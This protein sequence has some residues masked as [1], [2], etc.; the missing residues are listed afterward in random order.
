MPHGSCTIKPPVGYNYRKEVTIGRRSC[1]GKCINCILDQSHL[2]IS[3]SSLFGTPV[4]V[5]ILTDEESQRRAL[6]LFFYL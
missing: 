4:C 1:C 6:S 5:K 2:N 3:G